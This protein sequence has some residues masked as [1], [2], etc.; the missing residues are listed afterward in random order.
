MNHLDE[1]CITIAEGEQVVLAVNDHW[2]AI[3]RQ[4]FGY[5][6]VLALFILVVI[7]AGWI[8]GYSQDSAKAIVLIAI[9]LFA[10]LNHWFFLHVIQWDLSNWFVT[11]HRI[12]EFDNKPFIKSDMRFVKISEIHEVEKRKHGLVRNIL[13]YGD[14]IINVA[15]VPEPMVLRYVTQPSKFVH[16]IQAIRN[17]KLHHELNIP[18]LRQKYGRKYRFLHELKKQQQR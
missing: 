14:V 9:A 18:N 13:D 1:P 11:T 3:F 16:L 7:F 15:A 2:V 6:T 10:L 5:L 4:I 12:I 8:N 17:E